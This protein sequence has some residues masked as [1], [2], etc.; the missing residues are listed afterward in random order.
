[1]EWWSDS[2]K[3]KKIKNFFLYSF[4]YKKKKLLK[5]GNKEKG[6]QKG[7]ENDQKGQE[8]QKVIFKK[9]P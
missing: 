5:N 7:Q 6:G 2:K 9:L 8:K 1:L 4:E 3:L